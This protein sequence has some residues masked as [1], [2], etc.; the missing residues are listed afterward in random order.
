MSL[1]FKLTNYATYIDIYLHL[2]ICL[3]TY[4]SVLTDTEELQIRDHL[5]TGNF[6]TCGSSYP[7][8]PQADTL[9]TRYYWASSYARDKNAKL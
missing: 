8:S 6:S 2:C 4:P 7:G 9:Q 1:Y 5:L 3:P